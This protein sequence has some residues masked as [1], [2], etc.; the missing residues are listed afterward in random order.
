MF[1][2]AKVSLCAAFLLFGLERVVGSAT[3]GGLRQAAGVCTKLC[4]QTLRVICKLTQRT[5]VSRIL[6]Q[7]QYIVIM[8]GNSVQCQ[9]GLTM[10]AGLL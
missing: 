3:A 10:A 2:S 6:L 7:T 9:V 8:N 5:L 1:Y 4:K